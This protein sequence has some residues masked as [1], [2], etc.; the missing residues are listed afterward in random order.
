MECKGFEL[1]CANIQFLTLSSRFRWVFCQLEALRHCFPSNLRQFLNKLPDTLD[2]TYER[3]LRGI[4]KAQADEAYRLLQCLTV[5]ARPLRIEEL[6]ELLAFDFQPST[7]GR[8]PELRVDWRWDDEEEAI[9][10]TC[11]SLIAIVHNGDSRVV[12]FSHFSVKEYLTSPRLAQ[13]PCVDVSRFH[14]DLEPAH[15]IMAQACLATLLRPD[16]HGGKSDAKQSPLVKYAAQYWVEHAQFEM[17]SS[18]VQDGMDDLFD[19]SKPHFAEWLEVHDIDEPLSIFASGYPDRL[20]SPL[21]YAAFCG[22]YNLAERLIQKY[23]EQI[24]AQGGHVVAPLPAALLKRHFT[25]ANLL[26]KHGAVVDVENDVAETLLHAASVSGHVDIM[27]WLLGHGAD[28]NARNYVSRTPL[29]Y[30]VLNMHFEAIQILLDHGVDIDSQS[31][32]GKT[33]LYDLLSSRSSSSEGMVDVIQRLLE[34]G[35]DTNIPDHRQST[36]LH[37]ASSSGWPEVARLLLSYGAKVD[38]KDEQGRTPFE[39]ASSKGH[40]EMTKLLFEHGAVP[41]LSF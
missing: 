34:H 8:I 13:S 1:F 14:I 29:H 32:T 15:T 26:Y 24:N 19:N 40:H 25:V 39:V 9:L 38:E 3:M 10:S 31:I 36:A 18:R 35:A 27:R 30:A 23:P 7:P 22:F 33:P 5:A 4:N 37:L 6:A 20:G 17:V 11:S 28:A 41:T 16:E 21:Y 2:E 12:Q